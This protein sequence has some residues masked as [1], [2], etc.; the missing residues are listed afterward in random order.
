MQAPSPPSYP[1]RTSAPAPAPA[2]PD[3]AEVRTTWLLGLPQMFPAYIAIAVATQNEAGRPLQ[4]VVLFASASLAAYGVWLG[5][6]LLLRHGRSHLL[7]AGMVINVLVLIRLVLCLMGSELFGA[8]SSCQHRRA[9]CD[10]NRSRSTVTG[11][12]PPRTSKDD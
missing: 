10:G 3:T 4:I 11:Q 7:E 12:I 6:R 2:T 1:S 5:S 9:D 8:A